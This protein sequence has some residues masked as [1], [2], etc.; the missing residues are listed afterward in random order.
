MGQRFVS[1]WHRAKAGEPVQETHATFL[2]LDAM[3][4]T[5]SPRRLELLRQVR[6]HGAANIRELATAIG[7]DYKNVYQDV[8]AL[9]SAGLLLPDGRKLSA[10]WDELQASVSLTEGRFVANLAASPEG[11]MHKMICKESWRA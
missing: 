8:E 4:S 7:R 2:S 11:A 6:Q 9:K 3:L 10:S 1:A 5:L